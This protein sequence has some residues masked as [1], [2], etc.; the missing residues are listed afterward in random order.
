M[1]RRE[2]GKGERSA[3]SENMKR[4]SGRPT[5]PFPING[6]AGRKRLR[7]KRSKLKKPTSTKTFLRR[8]WKDVTISHEA[9]GEKWRVLRKRGLS[10]NR[11]GIK[12]PPNQG[13]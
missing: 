4:A 5:D 1:P 10:E 11:D 9:G 6:P 13:G 2:G 3:V 7:K 12:T 8:E